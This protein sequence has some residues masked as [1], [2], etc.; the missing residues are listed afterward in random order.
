V[1][2]PRPPYHLDHPYSSLRPGVL[3]RYRREIF[4][5]T[6]TNVGHGIAAALEV[7][8]PRIFS[9]EADERLADLAAARF[10][11]RPEV[12]VVCAS[13]ATA[14]WAI[15][16]QC[17]A[18]ATIY[19]DAHSYQENPLLEELA[20]IRDAGRSDHVVMIDDVRMFGSSDWFGLELA[21]ALALLR[22][23]NPDYSIGYE[24]TPN[25]ARDLLVA[26]PPAKG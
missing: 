18:P 1:L 24:D 7:G 25:A 10:S 4:I 3:S 12:T 13:S 23:I 20:A 2:T 26:T 14:L 11:K 15:L 19:L 22:A 16:E 21:A 9:I 5:E 8:F 6:G 17:H